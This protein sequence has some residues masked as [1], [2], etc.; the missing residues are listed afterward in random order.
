MPVCSQCG[1]IDLGILTIYSRSG[2]RNRC[3]SEQQHQS[4]H[5]R[6]RR[7]CSFLLLLLLPTDQS[8]QTSPSS[9]FVRCLLILCF[10]F[11]CLFFLFALRLR[12]ALLCFGEHWTRRTSAHKYVHIQIARRYFALSIGFYFSIAHALSDGK[13]I[14]VSSSCALPVTASHSTSENVFSTKARHSTSDDYMIGCEFFDIFFFSSS[15]DFSGSAWLCVCFF[16]TSTILK[17]HFLFSRIASFL[18]KL[19]RRIDSNRC[20]EKIV[21]IKLH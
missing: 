17:L 8:M 20:G 4:L 6:H 2:T 19:V 10:A 1:S 16:I 9:P 5:Q 21:E 12:F 14:V 7:L 11:F 13:L 15:P 3:C 18:W